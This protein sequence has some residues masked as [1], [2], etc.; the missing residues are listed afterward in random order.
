MAGP[1][2]APAR[3]GMQLVHVVVARPV[4]EARTEAVARGPRPLPRPGAA[5]A[6]SP[7]RPASPRDASPG[8]SPPAAALG[9]RR[10]RAHP[11][12]SSTAA[13]GAPCRSFIN[14]AGSA[15]TAAS[16]S[17]CSQVARTSIP[18]RQRRDPDPHRR[19]VRGAQL[20]SILSSATPT[21]EKL[22][23][24]WCFGPR[25][26]V[27]PL[28]LGARNGRISSLERALS[29]RGGRRDG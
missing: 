1:R 24:S 4:L 25:H 9:A 23:A 18:S 10:R 19:F 7:C 27:L 13:P 28:C 29:A 6:S 12:L 8:A 22:S 11:A 17:N 21:S 20:P 15:H 5:P 14:S 3:R 2:R 26:P 16:M